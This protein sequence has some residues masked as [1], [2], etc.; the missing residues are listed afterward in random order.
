[1]PHK[2]KAPLQRCLWCQ[3]HCAQGPCE[4]FFT[5][6]AKELHICGGY[7]PATVAQGS[8]CRGPPW[9]LP[10]MWPCG[11]VHTHGRRIDSKEALHNKKLASSPKVHQ[12]PDASSHTHNKGICN[13]SMQGRP[14]GN[15]VSCQACM[16]HTLV[17]ALWSLCRH[18]VLVKSTNAKAQLQ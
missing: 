10:L 15:L 14:A 17:A 18:E 9:M 16:R 13:M 7:S 1:M 12:Q 5:I 6:A 11:T 8:P 2:S 4:C 3:W